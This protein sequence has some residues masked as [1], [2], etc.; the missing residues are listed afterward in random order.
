[1]TREHNPFNADHPGPTPL[2]ELSVRERIDDLEARRTLRW[3]RA[4]HSARLFGFMGSTTWWV[5]LFLFLSDP[6]SAALWGN[7][8]PFIG[9]VMLGFPLGGAIGFAVPGAIYWRAAKRHLSGVGVRLRTGT[10]IRE[11][12]RAYQ[13]KVV[14]RIPE[15]AAEEREARKRL[16]LAFARGPTFILWMAVL[17]CGLFGATVGAE[18]SQ[19]FLLTFGPGL[20]VGLY[21]LMIVGSAAAFVGGQMGLRPL[22]ALRL[23]AELESRAAALRS[24]P[25]ARAVEGDGTA[26]APP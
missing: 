22:L 2:G 6:P 18:S 24:T 14:L 21:F 16:L 7:A 19:W 5:G 3:L 1:M 20:G 13:A 25:V 15:E 23:A 10:K 11:V 26:Q 4:A 17:F 9:A 12:G 8:A